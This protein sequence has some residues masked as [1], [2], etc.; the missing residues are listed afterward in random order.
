[1]DFSGKIVLVTG[2]ARGI[3]MG[4]CREFARRNAT[5]IMTDSDKKAIEAAAGLFR[6]MSDVHPMI[7]DVTKEEMVCSVVSEIEEKFGAVD[8]LVN[9]AGLWRTGNCNLVESKSENWKKKIDVNI[10][11]TMYASKAV[12]PG[13]MKKGRG[14]IINL[15]SVLG[16]YGKAG[17]TDYSMT[18]GAVIAFTTALAKELGPYNITVNAV[19]P[20]SINTE[21]DPDLVKSSMNFLGRSGTPEDV[22]NIICFLSADEGGYISGQN[23]LVDGCRK[24]M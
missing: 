23:I 18:K 17:M 1:M 8:I 13:M 11:G 9:N 20:G 19:A 24:A 2:G 3:G 5:V 6:E 22:A 12:I 10:L 4:I 21:Y 16:V 15:S 7:L 14:R